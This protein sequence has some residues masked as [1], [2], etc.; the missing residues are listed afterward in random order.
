MEAFVDQLEAM[1]AR[2]IEL[3]A[4]L[5]SKVRRSVMEIH[6]FYLTNP[7]AVLDA[8]PFFPLALVRMVKDAQRKGLSS[9]AAALMVWLHTLRAMQALELRPLGRE[10]WA[11]LRRGN[12]RGQDAEGDRSTGTR[13]LS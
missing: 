12:S 4:T 1:D 7:A 10:V 8:D 6:G 11:Q 3:L 2:E 5:A 9:V 13:L